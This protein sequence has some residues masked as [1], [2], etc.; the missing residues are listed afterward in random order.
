MEKTFC[1]RC[2]WLNPG[3]RRS[4][5]YCGQRFVTFEALKDGRVGRGSRM[6]L[7]GLSVA[8]TVSAAMWFGI[9]KIL[10]WVLV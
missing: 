7:I 3:S 4:C 6:G 5:E 2:G 1:D 8:L 10:R 9:Y